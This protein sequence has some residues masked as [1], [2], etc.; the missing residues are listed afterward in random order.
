MAVCKNEPMRVDV[1]QSTSL[2]GDVVLVI[3]IVE[4]GRK[5]MDNNADD[6]GVCI[7]SID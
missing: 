2:S 6:V 7:Q 1:R 5:T 3:A 4:M